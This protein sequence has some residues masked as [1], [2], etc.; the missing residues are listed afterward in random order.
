MG[1]MAYSSETQSCT[2]RDND[3]TGT[4]V[5]TSNGWTCQDSTCPGTMQN[6]VIKNQIWT[7]V[8]PSCRGTMFYD[9]NNA[10]WVCFTDDITNNSNSESNSDTPF[11][12]VLSLVL[13]VIGLVV[14]CPLGY[15]AFGLIQERKKEQKQ[16]LYMEMGPSLQVPMIQGIQDPNLMYSP[17]PMYILL[18]TFSS[19]R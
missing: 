8:D 4:V 12:I 1:T 17:N 2:C 15:F 14:G 16:Q 10:K 9:T 19:N 11:I 3:C 18:K 5:H 6:G 13:L 7:C